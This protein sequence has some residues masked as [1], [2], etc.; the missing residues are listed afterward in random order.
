MANRTLDLADKK[1]GLLTA[2][3]ITRRHPFVM[4]FCDCE[5]GG[6]KEVRGSELKSG[7]VKSCGCLLRG[8]KDT[9]KQHVGSSVN[10]WQCLSFVSSSRYGHI[11]IWRHVCGH[12]RQMTRSQLVAGKIARCKC[13]P[14]S[15]TG[16][17][18]RYHRPT[19][20]THKNML[21][22]CLNEDHVAFHNYGGRGIKVDPRWLDYVEF[23]AD[24]GERPEGCELD[25]VN[26]DGDYCKDNCRWVERKEN[27]RNTSVNRTFEYE[28]RL[29]C[30]AEIAE[31]AG[32]PYA[33]AYTRL[34]K[35]GYSV[36]QTINGKEK[37]CL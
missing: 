24:M 17:V 2:R 30:V 19:R 5:C 27:L 15:K 13:E 3:R 28:G 1:F 35:Y 25:R 29:L 4:W 16:P 31:I 18:S 8:T 23:V 14:R 37:K 26:N 7:M 34:T 21:S 33:R 36:D 9:W 12:V 32:I 20:N 22:R 10:G 11:F 6:S